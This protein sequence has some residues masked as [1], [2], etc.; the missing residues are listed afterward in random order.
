MGKYNGYAEAWDLQ[1][2]RVMMKVTY[3]DFACKFCGSRNIIR[4][5]RFRGIQRY[6]C[7]DCQ[8][9]FADNEIKNIGTQY[10]FY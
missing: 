4:Y 5:G 8:R 3:D 10:C 6:F 7:N 9:K 1:Q 2:G